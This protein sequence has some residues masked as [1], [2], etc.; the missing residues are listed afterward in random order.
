MW[1]YKLWLVLEVEL[2][3]VVVTKKDIQI[4]TSILL[5][6]NIHKYIHKYKYTN[7]YLNIEL[8]QMFFFSGC[9]VGGS[10]GGGGGITETYERVRVCN[11]GYFLLRAPGEDFEN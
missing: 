2:A 9:S 10:I 7:V 11:Y 6:I 3:A 5:N 1:F 4:Y 8:C